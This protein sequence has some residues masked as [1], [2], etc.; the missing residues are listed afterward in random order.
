MRENRGASFDE[1]R[2]VA[3]A[4]LFLGNWDAAV[5][6][7]DSAILACAHMSD[8]ATALV[9]CSNAD[10]FNAASVSYAARA[11]YGNRDEDSVV[12]LEMAFRAWQHDPNADA[13]WNRA[14]ALESLHLNADASAA[15]RESVRLG[16]SAEWAR[17]ADLHVRRLSAASMSAQHASR[18][19]TDLSAEDSAVERAVLAFPQRAREVVQDD[20]LPRWAVAERTGLAQA[21]LLLQRCER[22]GGALARSRGDRTIADAVALLSSGGRRELAL[23]H[24][25]YGKARVHY[26]QQL[27]ARSATE[28]REAGAIFRRFGSPFHLFCVV[29]RGGALF[30]AS[31]FEASLSTLR[32]AMGGDDA[33]RA[34]R[35]L[36]SWVAGLDFLSMARPDDAIAA[37]GCALVDFEAL[38]EGG[39]V[40]AIHD[41][42]AEA[43]EVVGES[44]VASAHRTATLHASGGDADPHRTS[45]LLD[46]AAERA[47]RAGLPLSA[48]TISENLVRAAECS[49]S[50]LWRA[51]AH[52]RRG[53]ALA[54]LERKDDARV[55]FRE[56]RLAAMTIDDDES[57]TRLVLSVDR[58]ALPLLEPKEAQ[59]VLDESI[60]F[61]TATKAQIHLAALYLERARLAEGRGDFASSERDLLAGIDQVEHIRASM[62]STESR[63]DYSQTMR[64]LFDRAVSLRAAHGDASGAFALAER[65]RSRVLL[66]SLNRDALAIPYRPVAWERIARGIGPDAAVVEWYASPATLIT[67]VIADQQLTMIRLPV[68][69][70]ALTESVKR[71]R[72]ELTMANGARLAAYLLQPIDARIHGRRTLLLVPDGPLWAVPFSALPSDGGYLVERSEIA[73]SPSAS[74]LAYARPASRRDGPIMVMADPEIE[75]RR[76]PTL[77][78]LP[79]ARDEARAIAAVAENVRVALGTDATRSRLVQEMASAAVLH[80][81]CHAVGN[82]K[83]PSFGSL[84]LAA[85]PARGD[86]GVLYVREIAA[87]NLARTRCV[88]LTACGT[89]RSAAMPTEGVAAIADAFIAAGA[90][91]VVGTL[92]DLDD[93]TGPPFSRELYT[94]LR[95]G[96]TVAQAVRTA[97]LH[98]MRS[99]PAGGDPRTWA[100]FEVIGFP[101]S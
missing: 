9:R 71:H 68:S 77:A 20:L 84:L 28:F 72:D 14:I 60:A 40:A 25:R 85:E 65:A 47:V 30:S 38:G 61:A 76:F 49:G 1:H 10:L 69:R 36:A 41:L 29:Y 48:L 98:L 43:A 16:G 90:G 21:G 74:F 39:N 59:K 18:A 91:V 82:E 83:R 4:H 88:V 45:F 6:A 33:Y 87:M 67:W 32:G 27:A 54:A 17:E 46:L 100:A 89:S 2:K 35:A 99:G 97:Q 93:R 79:M 94:Q 31:R 7:I 62:R 53:E 19:L 63:A 58:A 56:A 11:S 42:L 55:A 81:A 23:A 12:A 57:R 70:A 24:E 52:K 80:F 75:T 64:E 5:R 37:Y 86:S 101:E 96:R 73:L 50:S 15:F 78:R 44:E 95:N 26:R 22:I 51:T 8:R 34:P 92:W 13:A 66:D 3:I